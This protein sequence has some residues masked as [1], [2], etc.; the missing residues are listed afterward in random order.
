[1]LV[2]K[3]GFSGPA[4]E[5]IRHLHPELSPPEAVDRQ[6]TKLRP[7]LIDGIRRHFGRSTQAQQLVE[8]FEDVD[9]MLRRGASEQFVEQV[10]LALLQIFAKRGA[11]DAQELVSGYV[12]CELTRQTIVYLKLKAGID[13]A[14]KEDGECAPRDLLLQVLYALAYTTPKGKLKYISSSDLGKAIH[15]LSSFFKHD[16][17][18]VYAV[19]ALKQR[20]IAYINVVHGFPP[21][22]RSP[23][24]QLKCVCMALTMRRWVSRVRRRLEEALTRRFK[25]QL[26]RWQER[27]A[28][29]TR[30][31]A[32]D[33]VG[34]A[35]QR[36]YGE[37]FKRQRVA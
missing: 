22:H 25:D 23:G 12:A 36:E 18:I 26:L 1:M 9:G 31:F 11:G 28:M 4:Q 8:L 24:S 32:Y 21:P 2:R 29:K 6:R 27:A 3:Y 37:Q 7:R 35:E 30:R 14:R 19:K 13:D 16:K 33:G 34:A 15:K 10:E 17:D 20:W 5:N